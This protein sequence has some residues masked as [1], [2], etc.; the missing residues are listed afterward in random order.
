MTILNFRKGE[1]DFYQN[2]EPKEIKQYLK[3]HP[4]NQEYVERFLDN[5]RYNYVKKEWRK[6]K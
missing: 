1:L 2:S 4:E 6:I 3:N 5:Y